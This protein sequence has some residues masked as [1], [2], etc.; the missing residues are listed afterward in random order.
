M[1]LQVR[2]KAA[3]WKRF[4]KKFLKNAKA[5]VVNY[6]KNKKLMLKKQSKLVSS[7]VSPDF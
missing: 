1:T 4:L 2:R 3:N 6:P 7:C 5:H